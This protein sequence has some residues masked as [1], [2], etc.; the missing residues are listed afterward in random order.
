MYL[1]YLLYEITEYRYCTLYYK[2][3]IFGALLGLSDLLN[4]CGLSVVLS[5]GSVSVGKQKRTR[6]DGSTGGSCVNSRGSFSG[7]ESVKGS[8]GK[9][10]GRLSGISD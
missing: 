4:V 5:F 3:R 8:A 10:V 7:S 6:L 1:L 2:S 9:S